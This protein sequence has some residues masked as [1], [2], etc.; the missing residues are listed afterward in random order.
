MDY[1]KPEDNSEYFQNHNLPG[2]FWEGWS[3]DVNLNDV[4]AKVIKNEA[5]APG[6][7]GIYESQYRDQNVINA[8]NISPKGSQ[9]PVSLK[10]QLESILNGMVLS[11]AEVSVEPSNASGIQG[12]INIERVA[13]YKLDQMINDVFSF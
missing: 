1:D 10:L 8:P 4:K 3:P 12:V 6:D 9:D 13:E 7:F 5:M 2:V 11:G